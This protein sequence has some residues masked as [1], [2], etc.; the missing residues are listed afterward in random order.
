[1]GFGFHLK[2]VIPILPQGQFSGAYEEIS[3]QAI[4]SCTA[5]GFPVTDNCSEHCLCLFY[6]LLGAGVWLTRRASSSA[7]VARPMAFAR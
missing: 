2:L 7:V 4:G 3:P 1:M 5:Q 6:F